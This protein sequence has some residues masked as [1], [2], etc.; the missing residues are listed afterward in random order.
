MGRSVL[1]VVACWQGDN[2]MI[3]R[4]PREGVPALLS[5]PFPDATWHLPRIRHV[6]S[7]SSSIRSSMPTRVQIFVVNASKLWQHTINYN[8]NPYNINVG[9][10]TV[11]RSPSKGVNWMRA[12]DLRWGGPVK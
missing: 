9:C 11:G 4:I 7:S 6:G 1:R 2:L 5:I 10:V 3:E 8:H 12:R